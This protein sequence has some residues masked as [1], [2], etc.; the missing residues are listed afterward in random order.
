MDVNIRFPRNYQPDIEKAKVATSLCQAASLYINLPETIIVEFVD[1]GPGIYGESTLHFNNQH[2]V[3]IN[4]Q[5]SNKEL[6]Y[7]LIHEL[8]HLNQIYEG[9]LSVTRFGDCV[10]ES[11]VYKI[12]QSKMRYHDYKQLPWELDVANREK[13]LL[14]KILQ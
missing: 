11:N 13:D 5:L 14:S 1:L 10:W 2:R 7:P 8:L 9:R 3:R 4:L 6:I 12:D